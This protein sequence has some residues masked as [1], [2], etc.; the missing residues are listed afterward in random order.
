V[1]HQHQHAAAPVIIDEADENILL[2]AQRPCFVKEEETTASAAVTI[3]DV[4]KP[5]TGKEKKKMEPPALR[6]NSRSS[7][8]KRSRHS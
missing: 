5:M 2:D 8:A 3:G 4:T 6:Q 7:S 1:P